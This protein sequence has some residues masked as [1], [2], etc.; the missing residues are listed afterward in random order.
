MMNW[1]KCFAPTDGRSDGKGKRWKQGRGN[2]I[3]SAVTPT[4][5]PM[6]TITRQQVIMILRWPNWA[7][8]F[9][10]EISIQLGAFDLSSLFPVSGRTSPLLALPPPPPGPSDG[11]TQ[12]ELR[13]SAKFFALPP[14]T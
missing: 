1:A 9:G 11:F 14:H 2:A 7:K 6:G 10:R 8:V 5:N 4:P 12:V 13:G 3:V